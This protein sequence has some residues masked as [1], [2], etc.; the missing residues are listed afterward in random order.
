MKTVNQLSEVEIKAGIRAL[1]QGYLNKGYQPEALH[2]YTNLI[3]EPLY[4][5][6]RLRGG[7]GKKIFPI[8]F[9]GEAFELKEPTHDGKKPLYGLARIKDVD[10]LYLVEGEYKS[11]WLNKIGIATVATT[12]ASSHES[13][14]FSPLLGKTVYLWPDNDEAGKKH[15][16]A[17]RAILN[18]L[19]CTTHL[20]DIEP[21]GLSPKGD[22]FD[23][24]KIN[25]PAVFE[26]GAT[27]EVFQAAKNAVLGLE[28]IV[29]A[30]AE[31][32][33]KPDVQSEVKAAKEPE[34]ESLD[35]TIERLSKLRP[36][37]YSRVKDAE[38]KRLGIK[39]G[40]LDQEIRIKQ[41]EKDAA[42]GAP[43][44][45]IEPWASPVNGEA[46]LNEVLATIHRHVICSPNTARAATL[47]IV[48]TYL[49][50]A[51]YCSPMAVITAPDKGCGKTTFLEV[52]AEMVYQ[53]IPTSSISAAALYRTIDQYQPTLLIDEVDSFLAGD[54]SMRGILNSGHKRKGAYV[55]RC[56]G[57]DNQ[58]KRF[59][60][61]AAKLLSGI[62][63]KNL[64]DTITSRA[65]ILELRKKLPTETIASNRN[66]EAHYHA[67][68]RKLVRWS[69]D[70]EQQVRKA[71]TSLPDALDDRQKDNWEP[72]LTIAD[73]AGGKW[74]ALA[75]ETAIALCTNAEVK[76]HR[77][78]FL[79]D[80]RT[81]FETQQIDRISTADLIKYLCD[82]EEASWATY[83]RGKPI[84]PRQIS[85][86]LKGYG[87]VS[88]TLRFSGKSSAKGFEKDQFLDAWARYVDV[89][90]GVSAVTPPYP[91]QPNEYKAPSVTDE[92]P[93]SV[94]RNILRN[95]VTDVTDSENLSVTL[96]ANNYKACN[97]IED[98]L[99]EA[100]KEKGN[101]SQ[102]TSKNGLE[103]SSVTSE[104]L[105]K[106]AIPTKQYLDESW[107]RF[108]AEKDDQEPPFQEATV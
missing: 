53:P 66:N 101:H 24:L 19:G 62:S 85:N 42:N 54:E 69:A 86:L 61:W 81:V 18:G 7:D 76:S 106:G 56:E 105:S 17:V 44:E 91:L 59:S 52:M 29:E 68:C 64:H 40:A 60:T 4:W 78:E 21:L 57:D 5:R 36:A 71:T 82:D 96:Q 98:K 99:G 41:K 25:H 30:I 46:L 100:Q 104:N 92:K 51:V 12:G 83:N 14:D 102:N 49:L 1:M 63:A 77:A 43:F 97:G 93:L 89:S 73:L 28:C 65:V 10:T 88:N 35:A 32:L 107:D 67:I 39:C 50:D 20:I 79:E 8:S 37:E 33:I 94:T 108:I 80:V 13:L 6:S 45:V 74:P 70:I 84:N 90:L 75:R 11:D 58:M 38:A 55:M 3:G 31:N 72:L 47:W 22:V 103:D 26:K 16:E 48:H 34:G 95:G 9:N 27:A 15:I 87:I 2:T 23:W